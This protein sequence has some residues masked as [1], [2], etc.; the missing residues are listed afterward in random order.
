M[1]KK[2]KKSAKKKSGNIIFG[3]TSRVLMTIVAA[4][5]I[6]SYASI[7]VNP[8][9]VW[10]ISL[11]GLLFVPLS[12]VN[13]LLLLWA[14]KRR[15]KSL[16]IPLL[17]LLPAFFFVGRYVQADTQTERDIR[18]AYTGESLKVMTY[19]VGRF[20]LHDKTSGVTSQKGCA[21]SV[22]AFI[23]SQDPDLVCLQEVHVD[24]VDKI[25]REMAVRMPGYS[26]EYYM[27]PMRKGAFGNV[28]L[29][30]MPVVSKGKI[31]FDESANL[32]L[33]TDYSYK[34]R[35]FRV[36]NC[37]FESYNI[38]LYGILRSLTKSERNIIADTGTKM[39]KSI[40]RR[41]KQV[42]QVFSDIE[43]CPVESFVCGDFNDNP[44]SYTYY[45]MTRGRK[46]AFVEAG[47]GLGATF[48][49]LWPMLRIDY[50]LFP[51]RFHARSHEIPR[52]PYS[53]HYPVVTEIVL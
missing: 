49:Q 33:Y 21:D 1:A 9:K 2:K 34:G 43:A 14:I 53:D 8:A 37:H 24:D 50:V 48:A 13:L 6:L 39:K 20:L 42:D 46:D 11:T 45:R 23:R 32:A 29:S 30:K 3:L 17:A 52:L 18:Q 7:V 4:L 5:L 26:V 51:D 25:R 28:T 35:H 10:L 36:Y 12:V 16:V 40:T 19:N 47:K 41:P 44:M 38:S 31:K 22:F 27:F 15:S